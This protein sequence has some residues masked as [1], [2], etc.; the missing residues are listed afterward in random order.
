M[1]VDVLR[2]ANSF[3]ANGRLGTAERH[4]RILR[5]GKAIARPSFA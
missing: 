3:I 5:R 4:H 2:K 1:S